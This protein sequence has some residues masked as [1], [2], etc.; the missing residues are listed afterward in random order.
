V[1]A[2]VAPPAA[3]TIAS[4]PQKYLDG[5]TANAQRRM[6]GKYTGD[7]WTW[8]ACFP[9]HGFLD[10]YLAT[11]DKAWLDAAVTYFDWNLSLL[12]KG[13]DGQPGWLGPVGGHEGWLGE[14]PI[15]DAIMLEPMVRFAELVLKDEPALT[16]AYG[17][18]GRTYAD[19]A[20]RLMFEKWRSRGAWREDGPYG[21]FCEWPKYYTEAEADAWHDP[22]PGTRA[23]TLPMNMQVHWGITAARLARIGGDKAWHET[24]MKLMRFVK[25]RLCLCDDHY[26]WNYWEPFGPWDIDPQNPQ[27]FL[28]WVGTH[29]YRDYQAGEI[30]CIVEA[31]ERGIVFDAEDMKRFVNTNLKVMWNGRLDDPKWDNSNAGVQKA[32]FGEIRLPSKP[33]GIFSRYA[34]CL[35]TDL[36]VFDPTVRK[37]YE[38]ELKPGTY[39]DAYY[40][41]VTARRPP[42]YERR[43]ADE[44]ADILDAPLVSCATL[45]MVAVTP[46]VVE[47]GG[48]MRTLC[49]SWAE[50][51]LQIALVSADGS[52]VRQEIYAGK[53]ASQAVRNVEWSAKDVP[54]GA[55]RVRW[56]L[57][58]QHRDFP[59]LVK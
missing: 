59:I 14:H 41:N 49:V 39:Q 43:Y 54:P 10:S 30:R 46:C 47:T 19:M 57:G 12:L 40:R 1:A 23:I 31:Y 51:D 15:G 6:T 27:A 52:Q 38:K 53:V 5:S 35:W 9:M 36:A 17:R 16:E 56:T 2:D 7:S 32:V 48:A 8:H 18:K 24:A 42:S 4:T 34:G 29:P 58:G 26:T 55:Y 44:P 33:A 20:G 11:G 45:K 13:P 25:S 22:P 50:G 28:H 3:A 37:L 21:V